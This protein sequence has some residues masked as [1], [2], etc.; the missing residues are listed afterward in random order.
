[1]YNEPTLS[2]YFQTVFGRYVSGVADIRLAN[3]VLALP[4]SFELSVLNQ[5]YCTVGVEQENHRT[6]EVKM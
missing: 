2:S 3:F 5:R 1:M 6:L 4:G